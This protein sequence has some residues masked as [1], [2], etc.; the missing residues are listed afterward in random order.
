MIIFDGYG[1]ELI[2]KES[3]L[4]DLTTCLW[5]LKE[6]FRTSV[7]VSNTIEIKSYDMRNDGEITKLVQCGNDEMMIGKL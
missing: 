6:I 2:S 4:R 5:Q 1:K 7:V 3:Q